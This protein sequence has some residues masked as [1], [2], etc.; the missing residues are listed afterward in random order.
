MKT[1]A[2]ALLIPHHLE[3]L[4]INRHLIILEVSSGVQRFADCPEQ[5]VCG[6]DIRFSFPELIGTEDLLHAIWE[7]HQESFELKGIGRFHSNHSP[8]YLDF[9]VNAYQQPET[10]ETNLI[11]FF[12]DVSDRMLLEQRLVQAT[13]ET[14]LLLS[15]LSASRNYTNKIITS[16]ADALIVTNISGVIKKVNQA[17][18][19]L[20][21]YNE[22][23]LLNQ[24]ISKLIHDQNFL[25]LVQ[26][27]G[28]LGEGDFLKDIEVTCQTKFGLKFFV[29]F[30]CSRIQTDIEDLQDILYIGR[31][32]T[33]RQRTQQ[34]LRMQ[35]AVARILSEST[36]LKQA[37]QKILLSICESL[38]WTVGEIWL[39]DLDFIQNLTSVSTVSSARVLRCA[40]I[41]T[42]PSAS[43]TEYIKTAKQSVFEKGSGL[44]GQ[45]W[46]NA[47]PIWITDIINDPQFLRNKVAKNVGLHTAFGFP[48]ISEGEVVGVITFLNR[49]ICPSDGELLQTMSAIGSQIGQFIKRQRAEA[50]LVESEERYRDLF[51]NASDLIQSV[52]PDGRFLYVNRAWRE[53]LGYSQDDLETMT[54]FEMINPDHI[55]QCMEMFGRVISGEKVDHVQTVFLGKDGQKIFLEGSVNCKFVDG[56]PVA[57]RAMFRDITERLKVEEALQKEREQTERLLLNILPE[58]IAT[59]LKR[60]PNA[61]AE[62]FSAATV[63]FADIVGFTPIASSLS[64]IELVTLLNE[65]FSAFDQLSEHYKLEK[66]KTIGDAYMVVGGLPQR[67]IDHATAIAEMA[68]DM[69]KAVAQ[70]NARNRQSFSIRI[71]IHSGPVVAGVIGIKKFI[72]DLWGDTVNIASRMEAH[73]MPGKIHVSDVTYNMLRHDY[74]FENRGKILVKGKGEMTTYFLLDKKPA[75]D[76]QQWEEINQIQ[77]QEVQKATQSIVEQIKKKLDQAPDES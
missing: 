51:E 19:T 15:A 22:Q 14:G 48:I 54:I 77:D 53:T 70:F 49:D 39:P 1:L 65:I 64:P 42:R 34:R 35:Y 62:N 45:V 57:T 69:H 20:F 50:A 27:E 23:E 66:I 60:Q 74:I 40:D 18:Q 55:S 32:I 33:E 21:G 56:K 46:E 4:V 37:S 2:T 36:T 3:Y 8:L 75:K 25:F 12:E 58:Q 52:A 31:D 72:Y 26:Q 17:T 30:S 67:R 63:L 16:M 9:Y 7:G 29:E 6:N 28:I 11:I 44:P 5:V 38:G 47:S 71:G 43:M 13:N 59:R 73:G 61:I 68:L 24:S 41:W 76:H 10:Q